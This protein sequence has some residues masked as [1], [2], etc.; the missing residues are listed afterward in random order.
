MFKL[1][2]SSH[3]KHRAPAQTAASIAVHVVLIAALVF[4]TTHGRDVMMAP[5][6]FESVRFAVPQAAERPSRAAPAPPRQTR[7]AKERTQAPPVAEPETDA[8]E[9][10][11]AGATGVAFGD[12]PGERG[13]YY[14]YEVGV[15]VSPRGGLRPRYPE[16]L[17]RS[18]TEGRVEV[19][20]VVNERGRVDMS[21]VKVLESTHSLFTAA[22][23]NALGGMRFDPARVNGIPVRQIVRLPVAFRIE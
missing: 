3:R 19:E 4:A 2:E 15:P 17:R 12:S 23:R 10:S 1:L 21:T 13:A 6:G 5:T 18:G 16:S 8:S 22:V 20:F 9:L 11:D 7:P 14:D